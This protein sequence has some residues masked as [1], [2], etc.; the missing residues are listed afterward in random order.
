MKFSVS[1]LF[2]LLLAA[3]CI[4]VLLQNG[5]SKTATLDNLDLDLS[6]EALSAVD[7]GVELSFTCRYAVR[8]SWWIFSRERVSK[9]HNFTLSRHALSNSYMVKRDA[10]DTPHISRSATE[11]TNF[12]AAEARK[13]LESYSSS[14]LPYSMRISL[15]KFDLPTPMRLKAFIA[16]AWDVDT[17]WIRWASAN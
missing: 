3:V 16:D 12:I 11:A 6:S 15:N 17:G 9:E 13:L 4:S 5:L 8:E 14:A 7:A 10:Y 2:L 1:K